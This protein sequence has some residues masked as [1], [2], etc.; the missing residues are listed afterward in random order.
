MN[1]TN[2]GHNIS[3]HVVPANLVNK[4]QMEE[5]RS[6]DLASVRLGGPIRDEVDSKLSLGSFNSSIGCSSR[7]LYKSSQKTD[8]RHY[9][10]HSEALCEEL[11]M[12]N[13]SLHGVL[14]LCPVW[15]NTF[16]IISPHVS[17]WHVVQALLNDPQAL[18]HLQHPH[19]VSVIAIS[20]GPNGDI[21]VN[22]VISIIRLR[23][24]QIPLNT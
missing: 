1:L 21:K 24:P 16:G 20:P 4:S 11:E 3:Q 5:A 6:L 15:R 18:P 12:V 17:C 14:H 9:L 22:Q 13:E 8:G 23:L 2:N 19:Q 10:S 7:N